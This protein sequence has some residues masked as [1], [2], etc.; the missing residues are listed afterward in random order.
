MNLWDIVILL[1]VAG[2]AALAVRSR[3]RA[4]K[5]GSSCCSAG[6]SACGKSPDK[7]DCAGMRK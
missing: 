2:A 4:R 5:N 1:L 6:C 3:V 7:C